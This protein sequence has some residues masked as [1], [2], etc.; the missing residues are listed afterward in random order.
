MKK[1]SK[2]TEKEIQKKKTLV[3]FLLPQFKQKVELVKVINKKKTT[4]KDE[5]EL[6]TLK[7]QL[8][9]DLKIMTDVIKEY[10]DFIEEKQSFFNFLISLIIILFFKNYYRKKT[11]ISN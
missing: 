3:E 10:E 6:R 8:N 1:Q 4:K 9:K 7:N 11:T 2:L 5:E